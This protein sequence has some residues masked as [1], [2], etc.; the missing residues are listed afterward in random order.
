MGAISCRVEV[1]L[2]CPRSLLNTF[3]D[4]CNLQHL[5]DFSKN[6]NSFTGSSFCVKTSTSFTLQT[7]QI[8]SKC[9]IGVVEGFFFSYFFF[10]FS[11]GDALVVA[12]SVKNTTYPV[13]YFTSFCHMP[14]PSS[15][16][17]LKLVSSQWTLAKFK[18]LN[19]G[20]WYVC[21]S[22]LNSSFSQKNSA[23][24]NVAHNLNPIRTLNIFIEKKITLLCS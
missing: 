9:R 11:E 1:V 18:M 15:H 2:A 4:Y 17:V 19:Y 5:T 16:E 12:T 3:L 24:R 22:Y 10:F 21:K 23:K 6:R 14:F 20:T 8:V 7:G 13:S